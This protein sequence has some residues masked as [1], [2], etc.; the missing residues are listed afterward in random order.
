RAADDRLL[1]PVSRVIVGARPGNNLLSQKVSVLWIAG[2][3]TPAIRIINHHRDERR[4][5]TG[6][7]QV[8]ESS[9]DVGRIDIKTTVRQHQQT[10]RLLVG[11]V[12]V[13]SV[14]P[15]GTFVADEFARELV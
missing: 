6:C 14:N 5:Q 7:D 4:Y 13:R 1:R 8:V 11:T 9:G 12:A 2:Q 3:F 10:I 15:N